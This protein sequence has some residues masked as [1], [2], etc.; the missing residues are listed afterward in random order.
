MRRAALVIAVVAV[1]ARHRKN[2][3][4]PRRRR[5]AE[6]RQEIAKQIKLW[7]FRQIGRQ[8]LIILGQFL[9]LKLKRFLLRA[10]AHPDRSE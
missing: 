5:D 9:I 8:D 10:L 2:Q 3:V 1:I 4:S 6:E 7:D